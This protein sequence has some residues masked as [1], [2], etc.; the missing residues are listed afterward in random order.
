MS[1]KCVKY[2]Y[3]YKGHDCIKLEFKEVLNHDEI[4]TFVDARYVST[5]EA[6]WRIFEFHMHHQNLAQ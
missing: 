4:T 5:L 2:L 3:N 6:A 1:V